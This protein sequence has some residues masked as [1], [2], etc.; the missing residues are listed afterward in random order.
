MMFGQ[1]FVFTL[2]KQLEDKHIS[3]TVD[4]EM[5]VMKFELNS[6]HN[7]N[8][9]ET[10]CKRE[11]APLTIQA[12]GHKYVHGVSGRLMPAVIDLG[13]GYILK[14]LQKH[15][16]GERELSFY[17]QIFDQIYVDPDIQ[18][19]KS[20]LPHFAGKVDRGEGSYLKLSNLIHGYQRPCVMDLKMGRITYDCKATQEKILSE[21]KK[22]PP[23]QQLGFQ[24]TGMMVFDPVKETYEKFSKEYTRKLTEETMVSKGLS[25]FFGLN[26]ETNRNDLLHPLLAKLREL[27]LWF[28]VQKK[29][30]FI[31][32][33]LLISY[34][35]C[36][37]V[38]ASQSCTENVLGNSIKQS[39]VYDGGT[40]KDT[41]ESNCICG[42][43]IEPSKS[44]SEFTS[45]IN[46][47]HS[48]DKNLADK[49]GLHLI[50]F[51][52]VYPSDSVDHNVLFGIRKLI[53][54]MESMLR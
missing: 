39:Y 44:S 47:D 43:V 45:T 9:K 51:A 40:A 29:F 11:G 26:R 13:D 4:F 21:L 48:Q 41:V 20:F 22:F 53:S 33:S 3:E 52:H 12:S 2:N 5:D 27:E 32:S 36:P 19:L 25:L 10:N 54:C 24:I 7:E 35:G 34:D 49:I 15:P 38:K 30:S 37:Q 50:D 16:R 46:H 23:A 8:E 31:A 17:Q 42:E 18:M 28:S 6:N 14:A 1:N